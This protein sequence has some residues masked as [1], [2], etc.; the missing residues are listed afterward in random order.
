MT[1]SL[2]EWAQPGVGWGWERE[3]SERCQ[4]ER[5]QT[6]A[7]VDKALQS[8]LLV[9]G[10]GQRWCRVPAAEWTMNCAHLH[11]PEPSEV[12]RCTSGGCWASAVWTFLFCLYFSRHIALVHSLH[13]EVQNTNSEPRDSLPKLQLLRI[14]YILLLLQL[15][16]LD[17]WTIFVMV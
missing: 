2:Q 12:T 15:P 17:R 4:A 1:F 9:P 5:S 3:F 8:G 10:K 7:F 6:K 13:S 11:R 14:K 16:S